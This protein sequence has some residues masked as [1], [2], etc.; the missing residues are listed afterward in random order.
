MHSGYIVNA[1]NQLGLIGEELVFTGIESEPVFSAEQRALLRDELLARA[2]GDPRITGAAITGSGA[3]GREDSWSDIDLAFGI[4]EAGELT[5]VLSD[6]TTHLYQQHRAVHH[7]DVPFGAW[8]Y[9]VFLLPSTL[10]VD[11]A[12]VPVAEFRALGA[13]FRLIFGQANEPCYPLPPPP[14]HLIG[15]SWLYAL[16]A[17]SCIAR[18]QWWQAE[19]MISGMRDQALALACLQQG[20][21][22]AHGR[23]M[24]LLPAE[25]IDLFEGSL[26]R[27]LDGHELARAFRVITAGLLTLIHNSNAELAARLR[28]VI[29]ALTV[30]Q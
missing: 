20:L 14:E 15:L 12:F 5:S 8:L 11:L 22:T 21:P 2:A 13:T 18:R 25:V 23:G 3:A 6:W 4:T 27:Q 1:Y 9:R 19:Y 24:D 10:Q 30:E 7:L 16:H 28:E 26:V 29:L 17:R